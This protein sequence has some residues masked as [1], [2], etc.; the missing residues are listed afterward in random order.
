MQ[1]WDTPQVKCHSIIGH[2]TQIHTYLLLQTVY[3]PTHLFQERGGSPCE[4]VNTRTP[5][6]VTGYWDQTPYLG[7]LSYK[8]Y[9]ALHSV[10]SGAVSC[11]QSF[12]TTLEASSC[13][14]CLFKM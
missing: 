5:H 6:T 7:A 3:P 13:L 10:D 2:H 12:A 11:P 4:H 9:T 14:D 1:G 8:Y